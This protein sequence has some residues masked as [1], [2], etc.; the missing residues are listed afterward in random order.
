MIVKT[1]TKNKKIEIN[2][3][4]HNK[5]PRK[6]RKIPHNKKLID[7][8]SSDYARKEEAEEMGSL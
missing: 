1:N 8:T 5:S 4:F 3:D 2:I 6:R 7:G